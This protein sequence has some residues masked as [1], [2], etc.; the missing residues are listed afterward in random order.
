[1]RVVAPT[2]RAASDHPAAMPLPTTSS[3]LALCF[4]FA[5]GRRAAEDAPDAFLGAAF[6]AGAFLGV[7]LAPLPAPA[8]PPACDAVVTLR[9]VETVRVRDFAAGVDA[10]D[11]VDALDADVLVLEPVPDPRALDLPAMTF[12]LVGATPSGPSATPATPFIRANRDVRY[13]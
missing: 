5:T 8:R 1:M 13:A 9:G 10:D 11:L 12:R 4:D 2:P 6:F 3:G 7:D